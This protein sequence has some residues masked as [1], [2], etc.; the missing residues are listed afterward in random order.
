MSVI[1][2]IK[3]VLDGVSDCPMCTRKVT[4]KTPETDSNWPTFAHSIR[5]Y[6]DRCIIRPTKEDSTIS[7]H[8][9]KYKR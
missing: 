4:G 8:S 6:N 5:D 3:R 9:E 7:P 1:C 2:I